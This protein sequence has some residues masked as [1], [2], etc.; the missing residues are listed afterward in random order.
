MSIE[1]FHYLEL[2]HPPQFESLAE[3]L[4]VAKSLPAGQPDTYGATPLNH[5]AAYY[6]QQEVFEG[7][8]TIVDNE[9]PNSIPSVVVEHIQN[10]FPARFHGR[11]AANQENYISALREKDEYSDDCALQELFECGEMG[12]ATPAELLIMRQLLGIRSVELAC[13]THPYGKR[14]NVL[15]EMRDAVKE[16][17]EQMGGAYFDDP[18]THFKA[19]A[20]VGLNGTTIDHSTGIFM[21]RKRTLGEMPDGTIIKERSS[22]VLRTDQASTVSAED[23]SQLN[24]LNPWHPDWQAHAVAVGRLD[25]HAKVLLDD[26][27]YDLAIPISS[28]IYAFNPETTRLIQERDNTERQARRRAFQDEL[29]THFPAITEAIAQANQQRASRLA[30]ARDINGMLYVDRSND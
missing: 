26:N 10:T 12:R 1:K 5:P 9:I 24:R 30:T 29:V 16:N 23:V 13:L 14:M 20:V 18:E 15:E 6:Q 17:V 27:H 8:Q 3:L 7:L 11:S 25:E 4:E 19:K 2:S 22:F 21:T 28:T